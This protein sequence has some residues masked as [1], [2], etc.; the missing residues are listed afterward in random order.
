ME[1]MLEDKLQ[2]PRGFGGAPDPEVEEQEQPTEQEQMDYDLLAVRA[3]KMIFGPSKSKMLELMGAAESPSQGMGQAASMLIKTLMAAAKEAGRE[4]PGETAIA[5]GTEVISDLNELA[6][7]NGVFE[8]D[9]Q[10]SEQKE[11]EDAMIWGVKYYGDGMLAGNEITEDMQKQAEQQVVAGIREE[12][13]GMKKNP[14]ADGV[15][16]G[17]IGSQMGAM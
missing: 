8:Y 16:K 9:D 7:N 11:L 3:R 1:H 5:A 10:Q 17:V 14:I 2:D 6:K 12:Q 4:I 13:G 15:S